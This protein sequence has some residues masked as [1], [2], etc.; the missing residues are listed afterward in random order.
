MHINIYFQTC[1]HLLVNV[2]TCI[3]TE[4]FIV[5]ICDVNILFVYVKKTKKKLLFYLFIDHTHNTF[6]H[7]SIL[8]SYI[9]TLHFK[10]QT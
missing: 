1:K 6:I 8:V 7:D 2:Y 5:L 3:Y 10:Q 9:H 4:C